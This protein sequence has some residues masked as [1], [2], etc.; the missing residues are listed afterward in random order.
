MPLDDVNYK[1]SKEDNIHDC[2]AR[3]NQ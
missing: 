3:I 2:I 1:H